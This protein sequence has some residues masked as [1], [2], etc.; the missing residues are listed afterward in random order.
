MGYTD[1]VKRFFIEQK[2]GIKLNLVTL[3]ISDKDVLN[4]FKDRKAK[5][6]NSRTQFW[7][8]QVLVYI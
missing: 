3:S 4:D 5:M 8:A 6:Q 2:S 7:V 1:K